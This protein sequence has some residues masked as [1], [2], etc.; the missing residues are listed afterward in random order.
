MSHHQQPANIEGE[1]D[2][3]ERADRRQSPVRD[4][5]NTIAE[6]MDI[7]D[8]WAPRS[9]PSSIIVYLNNGR[10]AFIDPV[11]ILPFDYRGTR[12]QAQNLSWGQ[13]CDEIQKQLDVQVVDTDMMAELGP[14]KTCLSRTQRPGVWPWSSCTMRSSDS[15]SSSCCKRLTPCSSQSLKVLVAELRSRLWSQS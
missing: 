3:S 1:Q 9:R 15:A 10:K 5:E 2:R 8:E 14:T 13:F 7:T 6:A 4:D 11:N 12:W